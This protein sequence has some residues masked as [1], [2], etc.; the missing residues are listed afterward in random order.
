MCNIKTPS[1]EKEQILYTPDSAGCSDLRQSP[2]Y[3][4]LNG[5]AEQQSQADDGCEDLLVG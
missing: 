4:D 2:A 3:P 1:Y 5:I